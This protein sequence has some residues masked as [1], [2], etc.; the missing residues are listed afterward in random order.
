MC[1]A[2]MPGLHLAAQIDRVF[3]RTAR[4]DPVEHCKHFAPTGLDH[5]INRFLYGARR[6]S[7]ILGGRPATL[8]DLFGDTYTL[9]DRAVWG[10]ARALLLFSG[11]ECFDEDAEPETI[12]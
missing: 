6:H 1:A 11:P 10:W 7:G 5:A 2:G 3:R 8:G 12:Y 4:P 9:I